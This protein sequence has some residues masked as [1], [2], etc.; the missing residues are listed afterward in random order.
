LLEEALVVLDEGDSALRATV[1]ANLAMTLYWSM[2]RERRR[3]LS[4]QAVEMA[5]RVN[6]PATLAVALA[7]MHWALW[8]PESAPE[9]LSIAREIVQLSERVGDV[10]M[11]LQGR[12]WKISTLLEL[13][14]VTV[15][16]AEI[17]AYTRRVE[18]LQHP[19]A[20]CRLRASGRPCAGSW[21]GVSTR[22]T[23]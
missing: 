7:S 12:A 19:L 21:R 14:D 13:G 20:T 23:A 15:A 6:D 11:G 3:S 9:Q 18:E 10:E 16:T 2:S 8:G 4:R 5:R 22:P 1:Q 17:A